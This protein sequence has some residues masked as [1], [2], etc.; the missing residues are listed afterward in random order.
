MSFGVPAGTTKP[1]N[2]SPSIAGK[3]A[4]VMVATS[5]RIAV[6]FR[7]DTASARNLPSRIN[8]T[9]AVGELKPSSRGR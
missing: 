1:T 3:P 4:S 6:R 8:G 5:G 7:L 9:A 2:L